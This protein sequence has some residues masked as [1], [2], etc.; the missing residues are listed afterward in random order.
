M[1]YREQD[2]LAALRAR[3]EK[4]EAGQRR[5]RRAAWASRVREFLSRAWEW[6][7]RPLLVLGAIAFG[8]APGLG[9]YLCGRAHDAEV[10]E[11]CERVCDV[12]SLRFEWV[13]RGDCVCSGDGAFRTFARD[14]QEAER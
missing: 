1:T 5:E 10:R 9:A 13:E 7:W 8:L 11:R 14:G 3:V 4:L 12:Q 6:V 2:E